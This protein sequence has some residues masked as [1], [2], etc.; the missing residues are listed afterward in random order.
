MKYM[1]DLAELAI[2]RKI[3]I[4]ITNQLMNANSIEYEKMNHSISNY[5]HQK[6]KL[7]KHND[8]F[9]SLIHI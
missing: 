3:P 6:I 8:Y 7:E 1:H 5:T 9:L 2:D 4:I